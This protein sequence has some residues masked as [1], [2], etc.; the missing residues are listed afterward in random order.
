[1]GYKKVENMSLTPPLTASDVD[2]PEKLTI[3]SLQQHHQ[4]QQHR[5]TVSPSPTRMSPISSCASATEGKTTP[6]PQ[7]FCLRWNNYQKNLMNVF[8]ELLQNE[9]FVDVTLAC[10]G[11]SIKAHKMVL[12]ACSPYFQSLFFDNPCQHPTIIMR[13][14]KWPELKAAVEFMYKGEINVSQEQIEP[15][16]R[17]AEMLKIRGL[18]DVNAADTDVVAAPTPIARNRSNSTNR[19]NRNAS[20]TTTSTTTTT[21]IDLPDII[22]MK[23]QRLSV[24]SDWDMLQQPDLR[25]KMLSS[26]LRY[27]KKRR[28]MGSSGSGSI[29]GEK[30]KATSPLHGP[31][32]TD[33]DAVA[34]PSSIL[35]RSL[36]GRSATTPLSTPPF[37]VGMS[38]L[39]E[40]VA[41]FMKDYSQT[42]E[43][44]IKP[45]IVEMI[46]EEEK[47]SVHKIYAN[48]NA[49]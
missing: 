32:T 2:A 10:D 46:R 34:P 25:E 15:L 29:G 45:G 3:D 38:P 36:T 5:R 44:E 17:V 40:P 8:D 41:P 37:G 1:M 42:D 30:R 24:R 26:G 33:D 35:S 19:H 39:D 20:P 21:A 22:A 9:S 18:T 6:N 11:N 13:D 43:D 27:H 16:I 7:Q 49:C 31:S 14:V 48:L 23:K 4:Q 12:S 47:V 28:S